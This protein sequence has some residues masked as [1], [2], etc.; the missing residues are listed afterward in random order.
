[1]N[2]KFDNMNSTSTIRLTRERLLELP[3]TESRRA[4]LPRTDLSGRLHQYSAAG[5]PSDLRPRLWRNLYSVA[6]PYPRYLRA[7]AELRER[8]FDVVHLENGRFTLKLVPGL[9]GRVLGLFDRA[10]DT[11]LLWQPPALRNAAVGLAGAWFVGGLEFNAFRYGHLAYGMSCLLTEEVELAGGWKGLRISAAD[12]MFNASWSATLVVLPDQVALRLRME[13]HSDKLVPGYWWTNIAVP[14]N[15]RT[16]LF[17][18]D[19]LALHHGVMRNELIPE[20]WPRLH[21]R[22]W[23]EWTEHH[24]CIS[25]YLA[26]HG[27]DYFGHCDRGTGV[28]LAHR[29]DRRVCRGRKLWSVGAQYSNAVWMSRMSEPNIGSYVE[30]QSGR[31]PTQIE[32][33][34]LAPGQVLEWTESLTGLTWT[35]DPAWKND[36]A[37]ASFENAAAKAMQPSTQAVEDPANWRVVSARTLVAEEERLAVSR[38]A[39][40]FPE[41]IDR[42]LADKVCSRGWV[43][44]PGWRKALARLAKA[45]QLAPAGELALAAADLDAG[46]VESARRS[47]VL[48]A[49]SKDAEV[50]GW[51][52]LLL[53]QMSRQLK[54]DADALPHLRTAAADLGTDLDATVLIHDMFLATGRTEEAGKLWGRAAA[55]LCDS[56]AGRYA[57]AQLAFIGGDYAGTRS[58]LTA[59]MPSVGENAFAA[60][61]LWKEAHVAEAFACWRAG[62][63]ET[64]SRLFALAAEAAPQFSLG[65]DEMVECR[66]LLYYRWWLA[67]SRGQELTAS[68]FAG[69]LCPARAFSSTIDAAYLARFAADVR[70]LSAADRKRDIERWEA[71][72]H[73]IDLWTFHP[74]HQAVM[75]ALRG[76][77]L[78]G[79]ERL[80]KN[81]L[82]QP[83]ARFELEML[84]P[85]PNLGR[86]RFQEAGR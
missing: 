14:A 2:P 4:A 52:S 3:F 55:S 49:K 26:E 76:Q 67:R 1:M 27:S 15:N 66:D 74:L 11:E 61:V 68:T 56:D 30:L 45:R 5:S 25:A 73:D 20:T 10:L 18:R 24:E 54:D 57:R 37:F 16:K 29:A 80:Q 63:G 51:A 44:G 36:A 9:G 69:W 81:W 48:L 83:R 33:D 58:L 70:H 7:Q 39:V 43:A 21:G 86:K 85:S 34:Q 46:E 53:A 13:N 62:N 77:A 28:G 72:A 23:S 35:G 22:D 40:F 19:G 71:E 17:F 78:A 82:Y 59:P 8:D 6:F 41:K 75:S 38:T 50:R 65:R 60:W 31:L 47:L 42:Q 84:R 79:W 64:A 32:A 12:E